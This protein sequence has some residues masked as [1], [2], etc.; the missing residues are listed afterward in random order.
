M[1]QLQEEIELKKILDVIQKVRPNFTIPP[2]VMFNFDFSCLR[3]KALGLA[4][5]TG[6][7]HL[8]L[9]DIGDFNCENEQFI[10][11]IVHEVVHVNYWNLKHNEQFHIINNKLFNEVINKINVKEKIT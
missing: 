11:T 10:R 5:S 9:R 1:I 2:L 8:S 7:I 6:E 3:R 4:Y